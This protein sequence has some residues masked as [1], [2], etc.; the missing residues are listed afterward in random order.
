MLLAFN[1]IQSNFTNQPHDRESLRELR[2]RYL[3]RIPGMMELF[4]EKMSYG[5]WFLSFLSLPLMWFDI[6]FIWRVRHAMST[7]AGASWIEN[8]VGFGQI[9]AL[10]LWMPVIVGFT[11]TLGTWNF[12]GQIRCESFTDTTSTV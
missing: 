2:R 1:F 6:A 3:E 7:V 4:F 11:L 12:S 8:E 9:L 5:A 10:L